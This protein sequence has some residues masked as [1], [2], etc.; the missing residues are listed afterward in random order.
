[1]LFQLIYCNVLL[2]H[3]PKHTFRQLQRTVDRL[4]AGFH[5]VLKSNLDQ[6]APNTGSANILAALRTQYS[7]THSSVQEQTIRRCRCESD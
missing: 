6:H 5:A 1:M 4:C 3:L 2:N 7:L